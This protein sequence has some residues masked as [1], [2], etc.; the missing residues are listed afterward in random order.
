VV[1]T[2]PKPVEMSF[3]GVSASYSAC[4]VVLVGDVL[5]PGDDLTVFV[6]FLQR[7]VR[8]EPVRGGA[9]PVFLARLDVNDASGPDLGNRPAAA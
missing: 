5:E 6:G 4:G 1:N 3:T 8:H 2:G 9:V 7:D